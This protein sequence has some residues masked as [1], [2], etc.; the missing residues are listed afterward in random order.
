MYESKDCSAAALSADK[1][2][3]ASDREGDD[4]DPDQGKYS[5]KFAAKK[6]RYLEV[7]NVGERTKKPVSLWISI[8]SVQRCESHP[9]LSH[10]NLGLC[11]GNGEVKTTPH[12]VRTYFGEN[13]LYCR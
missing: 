12:P 5:I 8:L 6:S 4:I 1:F 7:H 11:Y 10:E 13:L 9:L 3:F 2:V